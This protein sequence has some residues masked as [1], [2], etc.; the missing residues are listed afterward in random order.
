MVDTGVGCILHQV[1]AP[2]I[3]E[4]CSANRQCWV[5][6]AAYGD[7]KHMGQVEPRQ[8]RHSGTHAVASA[9]YAGKLEVDTAVLCVVW[10]S[11]TRQVAHANTIA[12]VKCSSLHA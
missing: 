7:Q 10:P 9:G 6:V 8:L 5:D 12:T 11:C 2:I 1:I 4:I 3:A